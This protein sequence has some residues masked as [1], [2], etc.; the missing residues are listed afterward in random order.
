MDKKPVNSLIGASGV[1]FVCGEL[2]RRGFVVLPTIRNTPGIDV[3][4]LSP[5]KRKTTL[6]VK[7]NWNAKEWL[8]PVETKIDADNDYFFIFVDLKGTVDQRPE[9]YV[10]PSA[11]VKN[12]AEKTFKA[13][14]TMPT[15]TGKQHDPNNPIRKF[16]ASERR[17]QKLGEWAR[18]E[19]GDF[20]DKW[21]S[22]L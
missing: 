8:T 18:V 14:K 12:Y 1:H 9:Y 16:P 15:L 7:T 11:Y 3:L 21:N 4:A 20:K 22:L 13:W 5:N 10:V 19:L 6:Q 2:G 17:A